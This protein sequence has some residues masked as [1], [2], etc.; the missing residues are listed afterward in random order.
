[1]KPRRPHLWCLGGRRRFH[2]IVGHEADEG[3]CLWGATDADGGPPPC[4]HLSQARFIWNERETKKLHHTHV[5]TFI[6][7]KKWEKHILLLLF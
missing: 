3:V 5:N 1:M 6:R 2:P 4:L 7:E